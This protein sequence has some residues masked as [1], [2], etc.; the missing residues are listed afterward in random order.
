MKKLEKKR[1]E[2][3]YCTLVFFQ[4]LQNAI[5]LLRLIRFVG[6]IIQ[7]IGPLILFWKHV[8]VF[9]YLILQNGL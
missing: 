9:P 2:K 3:C 1:I 5:H 7:E 6:D 4:N 8:L